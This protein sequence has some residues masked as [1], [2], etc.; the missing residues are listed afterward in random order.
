VI[1]KT[2]FISCGQYT[3]AEKRLGKQIAQMVKD[4]TS[5]EPFFAEQVQDLNGLDANILRAL[6]ECVAFIV[7]LH[8]R[9][10]IARPVGG[11]LVRASVWIEQEIAVATYIQRHENRQL[12]IVAF[13]HKSVGLE[14]M[15]SLLHLNP[16]EF[17]DESEVLAALPKRLEEWKSLRP[18][19]IELQLISKP[20]TPQDG[21]PVRRLEI[22]LVNNTNERIE[23][24]E[25]EVRLP[26]G[27][28]KH[29]ST[30]YWGEEKCNIPGVRCFRFN[31]EGRAAVRPHGQLTNP[32]T[33]EYC[34]TCARSPH[35]HEGIAATVV[36]EMKLEATA[37]I[38]GNEYRIEKTIKQVE[39]EAERNRG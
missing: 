22:N 24:Y 31:Q 7:V 23:N 14:G 21:H 12:P 8:P 35:E 11:S 39:I 5:L 4:L 9:G 38:N 16:I 19:G 26:D 20:L 30:V 15:R 37:W 28:L 2:I 27:I 25:F 10:E 36:S 1:R 18:S 13:K 6:H 29:W 3:D 33:F 32:I 17:T 34:T